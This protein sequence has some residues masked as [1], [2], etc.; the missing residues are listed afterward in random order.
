MT[1]EQKIAYKDMTKKM[2]IEIAG[3][4][5]DAINEGVKLTKLLQIT[6]G[7]VY[8]SDKSYK[9]NC[10]N[11]L[12]VLKEIIDASHPSH[13]LIFAPYRNILKYI[14]DELNNI[15]GQ[16]GYSCAGVGAAE[17]IDSNVPEKK[18]SEIYTDFTRGWLRFL[19]AIPSCMSHGLN[20]QA[21]C[22]VIIWWTPLIGRF[23][24]Y[25]QA[26]GRIVRTGQTEKTLIA[27]LQSSLVERE[28]YAKLKK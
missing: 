20:L 25:E 10:K 6:S 9:L 16:K 13:V 7:A 4:R 15:F 23:D 14:T 2:R 12:R 5:I 1:E 21:K 22:N 19:V 8:G 26:C 11:K 24:I 27:H 28:L 17:F 3:Q 18:R